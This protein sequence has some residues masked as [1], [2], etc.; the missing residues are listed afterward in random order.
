MDYKHSKT[1]VSKMVFPTGE[2]SSGL[3][4]GVLE[5]WS[6]RYYVWWKS[7]DRRDYCK[8][9]AEKDFSQGLGT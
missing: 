3:P 9:F 5:T 4:A 1:P 2:S 8:A 7:P 6:N